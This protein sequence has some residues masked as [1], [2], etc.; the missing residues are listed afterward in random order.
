L[1]F[2]DFLTWTTSSVLGR[3]GGD[4][5][6]RS[7]SG[8]T[9]GAV[10]SNAAPLLC[11]C[12]SE[13]GICGIVLC[14]ETLMGRGCGMI[15]STLSIRGRL[16]GM[17]SPRIR[18]AISSYVGDESFAFL[19]LMVLPN[20]PEVLPFGRV[21]LG[22]GAEAFLEKVEPNRDDL[23]AGFEVVSV[24]G[25]VDVKSAQTSSTFVTVTGIIVSD[26][27][28]LEGAEE[29]GIEAVNVADL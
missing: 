11:D 29:L 27:V 13:E 17:R 23:G 15:A 3:L 25:A 6:G 22:I 8:S 14:D 21:A 10:W 18:L 1:D 5:S 7:D 9:I 26:D 2:D 16:V 20:K 19:E 12:C 4:G 28:E 24:D